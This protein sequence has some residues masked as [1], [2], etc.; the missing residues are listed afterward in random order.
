MGRNTGCPRCISLGMEGSYFINVAGKKSIQ[1]HPN[2]QLSLHLQ[3]IRRL[4]WGFEGSYVVELEDGQV[5]RDLR[6]HYIGL[7]DLLQDKTGEIKVGCCVFLWP[8]NSEMVLS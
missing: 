2:T 7:E 3:N 1:Y 5:N 4:W 6:G 8:C